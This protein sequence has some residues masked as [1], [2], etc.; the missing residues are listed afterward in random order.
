MEPTASLTNHEVRVAKELGIGRELQGPARRD[1]N[2][3]LYRSQRWH[4]TYEEARRVRAECARRKRS[5]S[6]P[7]DERVERFRAW[8]VEHDVSAGHV[9]LY[10]RIRRDIIPSWMRGAQALPQSTLDA[11]EAIQRSPP[12]ALLAMRSGAPEPMDAE[13]RARLEERAAR[14]APGY[15][16]DNDCTLAEA[17][18]V[19]RAAF[20]IAA[21]V[22]RSEP[23]FS[24]EWQRARREEF[25][26]TRREV[27]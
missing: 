15:A 17:L 9:G 12:D 21:E 14:D 2:G 6:G 25:A 20:G 27:A 5:E 8:L 10:L 19:Q 3:H 7:R 24:R 22:R 4:V 16:S 23:R 1:A 26:T 13:K 11:L 18:T